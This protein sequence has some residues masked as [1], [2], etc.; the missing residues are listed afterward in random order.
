M[1][2]DLYDRL[3]DAIG[4]GQHVYLAYDGRDLEL[5]TK[6]R[7]HEDYREL[8]GRF[9][10]VLTFELRIRCRGVGETTWK[11][12]R[13]R[14]VWKPTS[15]TDFAAEKLEAVRGIPRHVSPTIL[16]TIPTR[17]WRSRSTSRRRRLTA[18]ASTQR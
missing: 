18:P 14:E 11:R 7:I 10:D 15:A 2:W 1:S 16:P 12:P 4:E 9:V 6:G 3:S 13:S 5:M 17:T 8:F